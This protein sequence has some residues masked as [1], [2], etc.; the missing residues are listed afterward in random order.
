MTKNEIIKE[1]NDLLRVDLK[2]IIKDTENPID[3]LVENI[4]K[5]ELAVENRRIFIEE[6]LEFWETKK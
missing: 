1:A 5:L 2:E 4:E 3:C 6:N